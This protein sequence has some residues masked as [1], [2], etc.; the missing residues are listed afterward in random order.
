M[1]KLKLTLHCWGLLNR[2]IKPFTKPNLYT[3]YTGEY[4][5]VTELMAK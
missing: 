4:A 2:V 5:S 3:T 1:F